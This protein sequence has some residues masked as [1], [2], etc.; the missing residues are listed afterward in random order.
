MGV[1]GIQFNAGGWHDVTLTL[2]EIG[3][4]GT[5]TDSVFIETPPDLSAFDV[6]VYPERV[7]PLT[8]LFSSDQ[9]RRSGPRVDVQRR[10]KQR[11]RRACACV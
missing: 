9:P 6:G 3:C 10:R 8:V 5:V 11:R 1:T 7:R 2:E 4:T